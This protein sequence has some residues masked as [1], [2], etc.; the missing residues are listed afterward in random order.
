MNN[1]LEKNPDLKFFYSLNE[2]TSSEE[3][4]K[5]LYVPLTTVDVERTFSKMANV[6]DDLRRS[7][8]VASQEMLLSLYYNKN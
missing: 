4:K 8:S 6:L 5:F 1:L 7:V 2:I 3:N